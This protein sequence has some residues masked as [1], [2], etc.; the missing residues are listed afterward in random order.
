MLSRRALTLAATS[1]RSLARSRPQSQ[2]QPRFR[3]P[4]AQFSVARCLKAAGEEV[5]DPEMNNNYINPPRIKRQHRDPYAN[6][7]DK[8][9]RRNFGEPVHEDNDVLGIFALEDYTFMSTARGLLLWAGFIAC[10]LGVYYGVSYT[11]PGK[12]SAP[13]ELEGGLFEELGGPGAVRAHMDGDPVDEEQT[14]GGLEAN[15][16]ISRDVKLNQN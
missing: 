1:A 13:R 15:Q 5:D 9:E 6:W 7:D 14:S 16:Q 10:V 11:Y 12:P 4:R 8:Q 2:I 3:I